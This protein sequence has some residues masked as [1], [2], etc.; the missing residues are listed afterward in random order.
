[1][2]RTHG[3]SGRIPT[4]DGVRAVSISFV[5]LAHAIGTAGLPMNDRLAKLFG[6]VG[7]R[8]FFVL[9]GFLIT[10][11]LVREQRRRGR[12]SLG[13]FY[14]RRALRIFPAFY[15]YL[16][17]VAVLGAI[18]W[19]ALDDGDL[20]AAATYT[21]NF[22]PERAWAAGHL[23]SLAVEEQFYLLWPAALVVLGVARAPRVAL[24]ALALAP[25]LRV[26]LWY[27]MPAHRALVDQAFPCVFDALA[28]GCM[29]ALVYERLG[30]SQLVH[31]VVESTW[32]WWGPGLA[33]ASLAISNP[34]FRFGIGAT[35]ANLGIALVLYRCVSQPD[36]LVGRAL[37][38]RPLVWLGTLSY[39]LYLWQ[40]LF[41]NRHADGVLHAFP[42]NVAL[43]VAAAAACH[44][45]IE[46]PILRLADRWRDRPSSAVPL[47][48]SLVSDEPV[49][50]VGEPVAGSDRP[51]RS[52]TLTSPGGRRPS[53]SV[54]AEVP[55]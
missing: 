1:M 9:S 2:S 49:V 22:H 3:P 6:D 7:V 43:A 46:R 33:I 29:L 8:T 25:L 12:I 44:H 27:G 50:D 21:M 5:L 28:T 42:I 35:L 52:A 30:E 15:A 14:I 53:G 26:G 19:I 32:F 39:S 11:L 36:T 18:G 41:L 10:T 47:R 38:R 4:L 24:A 45:V 16:A 40:Q 23:W 17:V 37:E 54:T 55:S 13:N 34:A 51:R 20:L 31:R 48:A